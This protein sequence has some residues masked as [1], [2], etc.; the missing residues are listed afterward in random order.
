MKP[1]TAERLGKLLTTGPAAI[2]PAT[3]AFLKPEIA[4]DA[5]RWM[6]QKDYEK[7]DRTKKK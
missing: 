5:W 3:A 1:A 7:D 2:T 6:L 4:L